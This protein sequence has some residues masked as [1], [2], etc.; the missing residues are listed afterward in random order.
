ML[1]KFNFERPLK[2]PI[3]NGGYTAIFRSICCIGDSLS[4][5]EFV[6]LNSYGSYNYHD[7]YEYSWGQ[8]LS[9]ACGSR[10][11]NFSKGGMTAKAYSEF[12]DTNGFWDKKYA[13]QGYILAL[14]VNDII[15]KNQPV[16]ELNDIY[17]DC[18]S[19]SRYLGQI[20]LSYKQI[21]PDARFF[22]VTMP[23][24][25]ESRKR[26]EIKK[27]H[28][29]LIYEMAKHFENTYVIDLF[30]YAP[31]YDKKFKENYYLLNHMNPMGYVYTA[32]LIGSY[33]DYIIRH[34]MSDFKEVGF[35]GTDIK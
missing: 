27:A 15:N 20:I 7:M 13:S 3:D 26:R 4:S 18:D 8:F 5:G 12:A 6:S 25:N 32:R 31:V 33:I 23:R 34:N 16:G 21:S 17:G 10:V 29:R 30:K 1:K 35:I 2:R 28:R 24:E 14:G 11:Y 22:L 9:R 19:F